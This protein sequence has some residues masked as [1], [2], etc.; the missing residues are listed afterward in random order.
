MPSRF[1]E[2]AF[3]S[4]ASFIHEMQRESQRL[5]F[6][7]VCFCLSGREGRIVSSRNYE[8]ILELG[9]PVLALDVFEHAYFRDFGFDKGRYIRAA[10][11]Y[12]DLSRV[13][14]RNFV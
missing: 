2:E 4:C 10:L 11:S 8:E 9:E 13:D 12:L 6:G 3:G 7:F 5:S 14:K 1:I